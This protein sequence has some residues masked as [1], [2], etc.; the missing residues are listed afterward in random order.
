MS[1]FLFPFLFLSPLGIVT[2][3]CCGSFTGFEGN[4]SSLNFSRV[5]ALLSYM[6]RFFKPSCFLSTLT[7]RSLVLSFFDLSS[8]SSI[9]RV[10]LL[11]MKSLNSFF[12]CYI[13]SS[14]F[15][16]I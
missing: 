11:A 6:D 7:A 9:K 4:T 10:I 16:R 3:H 15:F 13:V 2:L 12:F 8:Y 14:S 5:G 1:R